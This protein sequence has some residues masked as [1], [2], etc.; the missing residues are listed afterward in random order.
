MTW[1]GGHPIAKD[2]KGSCWCGAEDGYCMCT[3]NVAI[4]LVIVSNDNQ[5]IWLVRRKDTSQL[6]VMGGFVDV[7]ET[8]EQ[9][10]HRELKEEMGIVLD[11]KNGEQPMLQGVY[12]DPTRDNRRRNVA[13]VFVV[14]LVHSIQPKASDDAKDV[15]K[16]HIDDI[17][18]HDYFADHKTILLD[19]R[20][21]LQKGGG[22]AGPETLK[23]GVG[24]VVSNQEALQIQRSVCTSR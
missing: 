4:D 9:A 16:I 6:A 3:P 12:S 7:N 11:T 18:K 2:H 15:Q 5:H 21:S 22:L 8:V 10:V 19:Y 23:A 17:E 24:D 20:Q 1:H 14:R 13:A